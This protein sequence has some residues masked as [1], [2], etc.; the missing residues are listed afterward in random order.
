MLAPSP[1]GA[2]GA[3]PCLVPAAAAAAV[4]SAL[5]TAEMLMGCCIA[6]DAG[7]PTAAAAAAALG[8]ELAKRPM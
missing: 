2:A 6:N 7:V 8:E 5:H 4:V 1:H 3:S